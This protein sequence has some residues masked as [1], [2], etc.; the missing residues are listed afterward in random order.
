MAVSPFVELQMDKADEYKAAVEEHKKAKE[1][2]TAKKKEE[3]GDEP[4][5]P[6]KPPPHVTGDVTIEKLGELLD[7]APRGLLVAR[8]ELDGWFLS[9]TRYKG[10]G[11]GSDRAG[12]LELHRAGTL[13]VERLTRERPTLMVR[14]A[15]ASV[16]GT[17]QPGTLARALDQDALQA[18]M[19][20]RF[21]MAMP[22]RHR[23]V[24]SERDVADDLAERYQALL[25]EL[26]ELQLDAPA[27]RKPYFLGLSAN[28]YDVWKRFFNEWGHVQHGAEGE[29]ASAMAKLEAY[30][31]RLALVYQV[32][33][34]VASG[35]P[36]NVKA[37]LQPSMICAVALT[38]WF[39]AEAARVYAM[40]HEDEATRQTRKL[41]EWIIAHGEPIPHKPGLRGVTVKALQ[42]SNS[43]RWPSA[44]I[45]EAELG[46]LVAGKLGEWVED[47]PRPGGGRRKRWFVLAEITSDVSD[48]CPDERGPGDEP[49]SDDCSD[50]CSEGTF[51]TSAD[52][53]ANPNTNGTY[54]HPPGK[55]AGQG[56]ETSDV[57]SGTESF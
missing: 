36:H 24:W 25:R 9:F 38:R 5:P 15:C 4:Q 17:I 20:A 31:A 46:D 1:E 13:I 39:A 16:T 3:R 51:G 48:D 40:L 49:S 44:E 30:A 28:A 53:A 45:A 57:N 12:W 56:S 8:D 34:R 43:R 32:V 35:D 37:I 50:D 19:G 54:Q 27:K 23:R 29:Q 22:P 52:S 42:Q 41:V 55:D 10:K 11:G 26:L 6:R 18:G 47:A 33:D 21:L 7:D 14:R 2:W